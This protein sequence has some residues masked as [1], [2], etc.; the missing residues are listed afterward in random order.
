[1]KRSTMVK[2]DA[3]PG[4]PG[5]PPLPEQLIDVDAMVTSYHDVSPDPN[6][7][8]QQVAFGTSGHRGSSFDGTFNEA[9]ILAITQAIV[10]YRAKEGIKGPVLMG[11]D[12]HGLSRPAER[13]ALEVLAANE[14]PT[15]IQANDSITATPVI[16]RA[17]LAYNAE[18]SSALAD[19][20]VIT[21][22]HNPPR[23]GGFKY[24]PPHG[25]P[26]GSD[27]TGWIERRANEILANGNAAVKRIPFKRALAST[28]VEQT[29]FNSQYVQ[30]LPLVVDLDLIRSANL[31]L[32]VHPLGGA[33]LPIWEPL[34][35]IHGVNIQVVNDT[36]DP[37]FAFMTLDKDGLIRMDCSSPYAMASLV[38]MKDKFDLAFGND[39]DSDRHGIVCPSGGLMNPN[40]FLAV[41]IDHLLKTRTFWP[42]GAAIGKTVVSSILIDKVVASHNRQLCEVPVGFKWF[43]EG[44]Y[45]GSLLF[46]GEES[47]GA[48]FLTLKGKPWTTDKDGIVMDLL[49]A[50]ILAKTGRDPGQ[51]E[52]D[53]TK[54]FG[55]PC[56]TRIQAPA[57]TAERSSLKNLS[58]DDI[59][60]KELAGDPITAVMTHA[61]GNDAAIGG[62]KV[63]TEHG[64]FAARP[65]G[66]EP[67]SKIYAES[68]RDQVHLDR[69]IEEAQAIVHKAV[70]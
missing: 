62:L 23:D 28:C 65:S 42:A 56:Y 40:R 17:I 11:K 58:P 35:E 60:A 51:H 26:A 18:R 49:A 29:D 22:S 34:A 25:G 68:L 67:I 36:L 9:H 59:T 19:G 4:S 24:N 52:Q 15:Q 64:W 50:E 46:G 45:D 53:L 63:A 16:S 7:P 57:D 10:E 39:P 70:S 33:N 3:P 6:S 43:S 30:A 32:G 5:G 54:Q 47:A 41:A 31:T 2:N 44:L 66:T 20:I 38:A 69:I 27:V 12:T 14:I 61:P 48:S 8:S 1:M 37:Q 21:P 55:A 13:T